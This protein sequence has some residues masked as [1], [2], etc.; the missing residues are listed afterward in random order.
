M[1]AFTYMYTC[2]HTYIRFHALRESQNVPVP[3]TKRIIFLLIF[4]SLETLK[5]NYLNVFSCRMNI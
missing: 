2:I 5:N 4:F 1:Y 3:T